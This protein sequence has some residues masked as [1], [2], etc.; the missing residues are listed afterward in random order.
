MT[1]RYQ[2]NLARK[3][4]WP[5]AQDSFESRWSKFVAVCRL[6]HRD[7][8]DYQVWLEQ[9]E[10]ALWGVITASGTVHRHRQSVPKTAI[11]DPPDLRACQ[12][13]LAESEIALS[14][15][16]EAIRRHFSRWRGDTESCYRAQLQL[17]ARLDLRRRQKTLGK[18]IGRIIARRQAAL[19]KIRIDKSVIQP[20]RQD[21][22]E[23]DAA[24]GGRAPRLSQLKAHE[25]EQPYLS[26]IVR[27]YAAG[28]FIR[29]PV[30]VVTWVQESIWREPFKLP[31]QYEPGPIRCYQEA[32]AD[33]EFWREMVRLQT[34]GRSG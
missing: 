25:C 6:L 30:E 13:H 3:P 17:G 19:G 28:T 27:R 24:V 32:K 20:G 9:R 31:P 34:D 29:P 11:P 18:A 1:G 16:R 21:Y 22:A 7:R 4:D 8:L 14:Q 12:A 2:F 10:G 33:V 5:S 23:L 15:E 26:V